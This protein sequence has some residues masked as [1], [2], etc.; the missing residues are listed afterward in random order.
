M[1]NKS[2]TAIIIAII[3]G[4][5]VIACTWFITNSNNKK[6]DDNE[7]NAVSLITEAPTNVQDC[8]AKDAVIHW[9][10]VKGSSEDD[11]KVYSPYIKNGYLYV[12][13]EPCL[14][15][16]YTVQYRGFGYASVVDTYDK[17]VPFQ[18]EYEQSTVTKG[19]FQNLTLRI[20]VTDLEVQKPTTLYCWLAVYVGGKQEQIKLEFDI[21]W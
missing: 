4:V 3:I 9:Q 14:N 21:S 19:K 15:S 7:V 1:K 6:D 17:T 10:T 2:N 5:V 11:Y 18:Y 13:I 8:E 20:P 12:E 16:S